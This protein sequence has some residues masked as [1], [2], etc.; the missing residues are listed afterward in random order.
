MVIEALIFDF[1]GLIVDTEGPVYQAW[2]E[3]YE[4]HGQELR[5]ELWQTVIGRG[6]NW[7]DPLQELERRLGRSLDRD[8]LSAARRVREMELVVALPVLPGVQEWRAGAAGLGLQLGVA[9]SSSRAW[10]TGHLDRLGL[11]DGWGAIRCR[12]DVARAKPDPDLYL[13]VTE[14]LGVPPGA[15]LAIE[16]SPNGIAAAKAAGLFCV[17]VPNPLTAAL[18]FS[19]ADIQLSSLADSDLESVIARLS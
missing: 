2:R 5:L 9:S 18:D 12:D 15:A 16:D 13:A 11:G 17:A 10:V 8:R 4:Q 1:D 6:S 19:A 7:F 14:A 3:V